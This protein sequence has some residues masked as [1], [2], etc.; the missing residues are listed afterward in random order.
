MNRLRTYLTIE[1][2]LIYLIT[3]LILPSFV[4]AASDKDSVRLT[5]Q[6]AVEMTIRNNIDLRV[7]ALDSSLSKVAAERSRGIYDPVV[8]GSI[9]KSTSFYA[10]ERYGTESSSSSIGVSQYL[11]TGGS[12]S[13][14]F[15]TTETEPVSDFVD[16]DWTDWYSSVGITLTQPLLKN[17]GKETVGLNILVADNAHQRSVERFRSYVIETI[18]T[19]VTTYNRLYTLRQELQSRERSLASAQDLLREIKQKGSAV[20][21]ST[22]IA[23][24][25]YVISKRQTELVEA[26]RT[27]RS[28]EAKLRYLIG[29]KTNTEI[30]PVNPPS[31][32]EPFE[33]EDISKEL[34]LEHRSDLKMLRMQLAINEVRERVAKHQMLP[35]VSLVA[36]G[37]FRGLEEEFSDSLEQIKSGKGK[38]WSVGVQ[39]SMPIGNTFAESDYRREKLRTLQLKKE[40]EAL[41]WQVRDR[42]EDDMRRL[43][44]ARLR[45]QATDKSLRLAQQR[46]A[47]YRKDAKKGTDTVKNLLDAED[48]LLNARNMQTGAVEDFA[49]AVAKL[50]RDTGV[51]LERQNVVVDTTTP[52]KLTDNSE[53][54]ERDILVADVITTMPVEFPS[55]I[56]KEQLKHGG[57]TE[58]EPASSAAVVPSSTSDTVM[59]EEETYTL[60]IGE[61]VSTELERIKTKIDRAGLSAQVGQGSERTRVVTRLLVAEY[62][63]GRVAKKQCDQLRKKVAN[64]FVMKSGPYNYRLYAGSLFS[65]KAA[66]KEQQRLAARGVILSLETTSLSMKTSLLTAGH[67]TSR[68]A[69]LKMVDRLEQIGVNAAVVKVG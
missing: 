1:R 22:A 57:R 58:V 35:D 16:D 25:E 61:Y 59:S 24:T 4:L 11:S 23:N 36:S 51:L 26:L 3:L 20:K 39:F 63:D 19:V 33:T 8:S 46:V 62:N 43:M 60:E 65:Q 15:R 5:R 49:Y 54:T 2:L 12:L 27:M 13:A 66:L 67:F 42:V 28:K 41:E 32:E 48:D 31:R 44:S 30:I 50:W 64:C 38:W 52:E 55:G 7:D 10:G 18:Y 45:V 9:N 68:E 56:G 37:G 29:L 17:S 69:A 34:A 21:H 47:A 6:A 53:A 40:I 14:S